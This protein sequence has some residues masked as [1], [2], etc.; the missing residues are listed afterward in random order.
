MGHIV[1]VSTHTQGKPPPG[2]T[3]QLDVTHMNKR[4]PKLKA[5]SD[6]SNVVGA[7]NNNAPMRGDKMSKG[8]RAVNHASQH[9]SGS[10][11]KGKSP[12]QQHYQMQ[13]SSSRLDQILNFSNID[14]VGNMTTGSS[15][16]NLMKVSKTN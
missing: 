15:S 11:V 16:I 1:G 14:E 9:T 4:S 6:G 5:P 10:L 7:N 12:R 8:G 2:V 13:N 3:R